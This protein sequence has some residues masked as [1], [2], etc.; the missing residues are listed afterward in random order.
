MLPMLCRVSMG[1]VKA[2]IFRNMAGQPIRFA[3]MTVGEIEPYLGEAARRRAC[4]HG[5]LHTFFPCPALANM[6]PT[7]KADRFDADF[8]IQERFK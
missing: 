1:S 8:R 4:S 7:L 2:E 6:S 5:G 3:A